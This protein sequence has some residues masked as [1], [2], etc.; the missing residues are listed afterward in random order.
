MAG[1]GQM[2]PDLMR[3]ARLQ[4]TFDESRPLE[5]FEH[6]NV[7]DRLAPEIATFGRTAPPIAAILHQPRA[8]RAGLDRSVRQRDVP[9]AHGVAP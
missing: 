7:R 4:A 8:N 5:A 1:L 9:P 3:A 6:A 2:N